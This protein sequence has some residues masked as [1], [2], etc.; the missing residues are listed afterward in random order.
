[1]RLK[2]SD[3]PKSVVQQYDLE[4]KSTK[5][6]YVNVEIKRGMHGLL[7][8]GL[9]LQKLLEKRLNKK[10]YQKIKTTLGF[11]KHDWRPI[12]LSLCADDFGVKYVGKQHSE[13]LMTVLRED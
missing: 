10:G 1:M 13:H 6:G 11:W 3:L 9:I 5:D 12:H 4:A 8:A 2:L 7:Q